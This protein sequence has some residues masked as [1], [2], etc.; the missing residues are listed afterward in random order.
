MGV[1]KEGKAWIRAEYINEGDKIV[2]DSHITLA[3]RKS[4]EPE[5]KN[6]EILTVQKVAG[7]FP[8]TRRITVAREN[9]ETFSF[10]MENELSA[11]KSQNPESGAVSATKG[12]SSVQKVVP[13]SDTR[14]LFTA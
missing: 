9:G 12:L 7:Q 14:S 4:V 6:E 2:T 8:R 13:R 3:A 5:L 11:S 1:T 10:Y